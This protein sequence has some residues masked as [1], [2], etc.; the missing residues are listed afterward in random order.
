[1]KFIYPQGATPLNAD[2][3]AQ[4]IPSH[5]TIQQQLN[6]WEATNIQEAR[7]WAFLQRRI[8]NVLDIRFIK[9]LHKKMFDKTWLW[10][11]QWRTHQTNIGVE[12]YR[13]IAELGQLLDDIQFY[14][15]EG[16]YDFEETA[17]RLHHKLVW[18][19]PFPNGNGR[20]ARLMADILLFDAGKPLFDWGTNSED[21]RSIYIAA[22]Q[23]ADQFDFEPLL[24]FVH[25]KHLPEKL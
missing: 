2:C 11:G 10:A 1:M 23:A 17:A 12:S 7:K 8:K 5:I 19:H 14:I 16:V 4:L 25:C 6:E 9:I 20:F 24:R 3:A 22:L 21:N 13:I 18:I 15:D